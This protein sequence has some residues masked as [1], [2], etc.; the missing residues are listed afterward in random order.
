MFPSVIVGD[1]AG[2][3]KVLADCALA[4]LWKPSEYYEGDR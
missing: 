3:V 4:L 1:I 2:I